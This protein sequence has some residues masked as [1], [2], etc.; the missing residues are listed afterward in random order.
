MGFNWNT[1]AID[2]ESTKIHVYFP[3]FPA[4]LLRY[5]QILDVES[6]TNN[7][8]YFLAFPAVPL[9]CLLLDSPLSSLSLTRRP[10]CERR[11]GI[12]RLGHSTLSLFP[13][14]WQ[15]TPHLTLAFTQAHLRV[16]HQ[17]RLSLL[18]SKDSD[19][20]LDPWVRFHALIQVLTV[21]FACSTRP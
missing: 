7:P 10:F 13:L 21:L 5:T 12:S 4:I 9:R 19:Q 11:W 6:F 20:W 8:F 14:P 15:A 3:I 18:T 17:L 1:R 2:V 16:A